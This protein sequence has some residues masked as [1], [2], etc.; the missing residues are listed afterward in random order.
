MFQV[1]SR[2]SQ[3]N[4]QLVRTQSLGSV[5]GQTIDSVWPSDDNSSCE[6]DNRSINGTGQGVRKQKQKEW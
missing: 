5:G 6:S 1:I 4:R 3:D 2:R